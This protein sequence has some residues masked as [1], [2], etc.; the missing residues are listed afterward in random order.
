MWPWFSCIKFSIFS[1]NIV[2]IV[3]VLLT[4]LVILIVWWPSLL[5]LYA[6]LPQRR[7]YSSIHIWEV[8]WGP[9]DFSWTFW[10]QIKSEST[11]RSFGVT[12]PLGWIL[13]WLTEK[14]FSAECWSRLLWRLSNG[15]GESS[16]LSASFRRKY[17]GL[18]SAWTQCLKIASTYTWLASVD[19]KSCPV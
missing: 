17:K 18:T 15:D 16:S 3:R 9:L 19:G 11:N 12:K 2:S 5:C 13:L 1:L 8:S 7:I 4:T 6:H 14:I 10:L